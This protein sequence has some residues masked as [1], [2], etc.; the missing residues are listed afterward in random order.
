MTKARQVR[1]NC[2]GAAATHSL[3]LTLAQ[4]LPTR[5]SVHLTGELGVGKTVFTRA[6]L[7]GCGVE[8]FIP[9]PTFALATTYE[10]AGRCLCHLD[11]FR[12]VSPLEW[13]DAGLME[14]M[15]A[16]DFIVIEWPEKAHGLGD[17]DVHVTITEGSDLDER[18]LDF[19]PRTAAGQ[20]WVAYVDN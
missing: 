3:G 6:L 11:F 5:F 14:T 4:F 17:P 1:V 20:K 18:L 15:T 9:S 13:L 7:Q 12:C 10:A 19:V 8:G 16:A 2:K